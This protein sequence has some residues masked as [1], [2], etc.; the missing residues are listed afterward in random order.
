MNQLGALASFGFS[1]GAG[2][3]KNSPVVTRINNGEDP[4]T[5]V[6]EELPNYPWLFPMATEPARFL[7]IAL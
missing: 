7:E 5:V 1:V 2:I 3:T 6:E 4:N